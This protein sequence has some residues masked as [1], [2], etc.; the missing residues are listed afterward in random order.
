MRDPELG[1][2]VFPDK[3]LGVHISDV[4]HGLSFNP[5]SKIVSADQQIPLVP[6]CLRKMADYI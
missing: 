5:L 4:R 2:N 1:D 6:Y 3:L